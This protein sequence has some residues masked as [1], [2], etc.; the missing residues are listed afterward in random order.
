MIGSTAGVVAPCVQWKYSGK[1]VVAASD[2]IFRRGVRVFLPV[3]VF[4]RWEF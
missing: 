3:L 4:F 1:T 2:L